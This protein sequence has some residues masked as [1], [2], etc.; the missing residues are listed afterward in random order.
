V[1][2]RAAV[3][4]VLSVREVE[5]E[6]P[7]DPEELEPGIGLRAMLRRL[8]EEYPNLSHWVGGRLDIEVPAILVSVGVHLALLLILAFAVHT[9]A[10][11]VQREFQ[12]QV[13]DTVLKPDLG[14]TDFQ[15]LDQ[16]AEPPAV[17]PAA[18]SFSPNLGTLTVSAPPVA[19][20]LNVAPAGTAASAIE[21][22][23]LDV[24]RATEV[25]VPSASMLSQSVSIKGSG[26]EHAGEVEGA[27]DRVAVEILRHLE[28]SRT[29]V[30]WAFD[31]SRSLLVERERL[32]KH[33]DAVYSHVLQGDEKNLAGDGLLTMVVA[34]GQGRSPMLPHP[35]ADKDEIIA[36]INAVPDDTTGFESTFETVGWICQKWGRY[37]DAKGH[38]YHTMVIVVTDE[39]GD[40]ENYLEDA[41][42]EAKTAKV[43]VYVLGSPA[44]FGRREGFMDFTDPKTKQTFHHLPVRQGPESLA[45]EQIRLPYW[46]SGPQ[47]EILDAGFGPYALSRLAGAT[48]GIYFITRL[49]TARMGA[50]PA[51]MQEYKP[52]WVSQRQYEL[53]R[54]ERNSIRPAVLEAALITQQQLP[55]QPSLTFPSAEG[56]EFKE[57]MA[58]NQE[59]VARI[60]YT[61][62]EALA[63]IT[64]AAKYR[65]KEPSRRW[66]A[67][68]DLIRGRLLAMKIRCT[69]FNWACAQMKKDAPKFTNPKHN[70]WR[71]VP[72]EEIHFS[73]K[74]AAAGKEAKAMLKRVVDEHP[75]TPWAK[76]A[77]RELKDA[78][79]FKW[80]ETYVPPIVRNQP[81]DTPE[82]K[83]KK[84]MAKP[85]PKPAEIPKL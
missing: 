77:E 21:L 47:Y 36:A 24:R 46:Y 2:I 53:M 25:A 43:P 85:A 74:A 63:P 40:D 14:H 20:A 12:S 5:R 56:P 79:G 1:G 8:D 51:S 4:D 71:L 3:R 34:F 70:A 54:H 18:G 35:T 48:G 6:L 31:A 22:A 64:Q 73:L 67:H 78:F 59:I 16:S 32:S 57:A 27:V 55:G 45:L 39:V 61:V 50:D 15:D 42:N 82:A 80:M 23:K 38:A 52:D 41:I 58:K 68:Y 60:L 44:I 75:G 33:I 76:L 62:D 28:K 65:D 69:E 84:E 83:K 9:T 26:A 66:Q 72:D 81:K 10:G 7:E 17:A 37:K 11:E 19:S 29:L 49:G 30:V 13:V